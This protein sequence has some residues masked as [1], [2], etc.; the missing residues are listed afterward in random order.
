MTVFLDE[1][2]SLTRK[3][4]RESEESKPLP[5]LEEVCAL[6]DPPPSLRA[7]V[8]RKEGERIKVIAEVKRS[9]PSR[10]PIRPDLVLEDLVKQYEE[11]GASAI[12]V[13]T[14]P[15]F[16]GGS[17]SDLARASE[18]TS[19]PVLRKDF[20]TE[21]YQ[22]LE[23]RAAGAAAV[24]LIVA[25]LDRARLEGLLAMS[26]SLGME[27]L[28]EVHDEKELSLALESGAGMIGV[29]NRDLKTLQ[30]DMETTLSLAPLVPE[31]LTLVSE[32]GYTQPHQVR[33][34]MARGV[35]AILV[36]ELL[37]REGNPQRSIT[38]LV[39]GDDHAPA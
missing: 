7:S 11:G 9:S 35:D 5:I 6:L 14:E 25:I 20:I 27:A 28:V 24:L 13:L 17:L 34:A 37:V 36:G 30:V 12:S 22:L 16:F 2:M 39:G 19:L 26:A 10:G 21:P 1:V 32:S 33:E 23:A 3:R 38:M 8:S 29:N 4:V 31:S 18:I 15:A